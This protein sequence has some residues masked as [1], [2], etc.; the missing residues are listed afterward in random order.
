MDEDLYSL[1]QNADSATLQSM[2]QAGLA[3]GREAA[4]QQ[5]LNQPMAQG[6]EVGRT[7]VAA[8][9]LEHLAN[10]VRAVVGQRKMNDLTNQ[11]GSGRLAYLRMLAGKPVASAGG[12]VPGAP[13]P[14][15]AG[16]MTGMFG[17]GY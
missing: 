1:I 17:P 14:I 6:R 16:D 3:P 5:G 15:G 4:L 8:S 10:A 7:Y 12:P 11:Q 13:Q 2:I 9:P